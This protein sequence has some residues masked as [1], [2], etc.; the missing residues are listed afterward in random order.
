MGNWLPKSVLCLKSYTER[1]F[2]ADL[3]AGITVGLVA[4]PLAMAF[5]IAS[6]VP[7]QMG[8]YC[9]IVAGFAISALGGSS[10]QIGGPTGAFVVVVFGIVAKHGVDGLFMCTLMA[11]VILLIL[12]ATGL[13][14]AVKFIPR[15]V[16]VGFTNGIAV[17]IA[18]TQI[19]DFFGLKIDKVP[20]EFAAR[21]LTYAHNFSSF[22]PLET[23]L[24]VGALV[25][26]IFF[27][28]FV[29]RVP[30]YIVALFAGTAVV[31]IFKLPVETIGT[32][33]GGIP[34]GF[35]KLIIPHF[36]V[37]LLRPLISPAITVAML[38]AIES[39]MSAV[40]SDRMSGDKHNPNVELIGQGVA[41]ILSPLF[42]GLPATGA[43]ARTAT[44]IRS[45]A[46][47]PVAGMIHALTLLAIILFAAPLARFI[48]LSV[49]AAIL[50]VVSYN[51]GEWREIPEILKQ[52]RF[53][54]AAWLVTFLL[55]VFADLTVAVE[56]GM[57]L[58]VLVFIRKVTQTTTVSEATAEYIHEGHVHILQHKEIPSY[59][60]IFRIHGP[61]LFGSTDKIDMIV[62]RLP[63]LPPIIILRLRNMT[64][65]DSTGLQALENFA[66]RVHESGREL[67][68][69]GAR[70]QPAKRLHEAEFHPHVAEDNICLSVA[71]ALDRARDLYP[72]VVKRHPAGTTWGRRS[73]DASLATP[74]V[75]ASSGNES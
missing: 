63:D 58:A 72:D 36:R 9:A 6:G 71:E 17:I 19:K 48:P 38:G 68:L 12:G 8:L 56:A 49:L 1:M 28:I 42:G 54:I 75:T 64:A 37:D 40:V 7:P 35:P 32:R 47:T 73:S 62:S 14:T 27:M 43:I 61:F 29:K 13:G 5:A 24:A 33:F 39:L 44:N 26:I 2:V 20:G 59:V 10:T 52:S 30:G 3:L 55:T 45:G 23:T 25:V 22:S 60:S 70:E 65:I 15:P 69:C 16:V 67:I 31:V 34:S 51:M 21:I 66:D 4:L 57:I 11:G 74:V 46:K 50:L 53:E 18:S 41:N